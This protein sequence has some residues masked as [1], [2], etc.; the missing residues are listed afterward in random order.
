MKKA[1]IAVGLVLVFG[2]FT[3][4]LVL[5]QH[6]RNIRPRLLAGAAVAILQAMPHPIQQA[7]PMRL[8]PK[9]QMPLVEK[10]CQ[11]LYRYSDL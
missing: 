3:Q 2:L 4:R 11:W 8:T 10:H 6:S 9:A 5:H 1:L 7:L